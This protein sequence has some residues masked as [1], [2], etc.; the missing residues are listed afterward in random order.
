MEAL[1]IIGYITAFLVG[2]VL[3]M[4]GGGGSI[5]TVPILVYLFKFNPV[6]ATVYSLFVVGTSATIGTLA[7]IRKHL[8]N[9]RVAL[10]FALPSFVSVFLT[11]RFVIPT[12]PDV[13][14][15]FRGYDLTKE[16]GLMLFFSNIILISA[17]FM[18]KNYNSTST[19]E[20]QEKFNYSALIFQGFGV[21]ILTGLVGAG[22]GFIIVPA[23]VLLAQI[24]I[25]QAIATSMFIVSCNSLLGFLTDLSTFTIDW[26]FLCIFSSFSIVGIFIGL[27]LADR[28]HD[29]KL[30]SYFGWFM[31]VMGVVILIKE[32]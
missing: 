30:K 6:V 15:S 25:K 16:V 17:Y 7:N 22:G 31:L 29:N 21:G 13:I 24:P 26:V 1:E 9:F 3:G 20:L 5:L 19:F 11:R 8:I 14:W 32:L 4:I 12:L 10:I 28:F 27:R 18:I 2:V 23:L